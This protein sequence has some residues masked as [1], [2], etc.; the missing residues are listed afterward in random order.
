MNTSIFSGTRRTRR[1]AKLATAALLP[2]ALIGTLTSALTAA[3]AHADIDSTAAISAQT[4][5]MFTTASAW[6]PKAPSNAPGWKADFI[7]NFDGP[8]NT[9][10]WGRYQGGAPAGSH[11]AYTLANA[12]VTTSPTTTNSGILQLRTKYENGAWTSAGMSSGRGFAAVQGKWAI[13]ARFERG[14]GVGY[15][16]L[17]Y[18]KGGAWPPEVDLAEGTAGGASI[19]STVHYGT[20]KQNYQIQRWQHN[21]DMTKWHTYGVIISTGLIEYTL[22]GRVWGSVQ[23]DQTPDVP[24]WLGVQSG[25][26]DCAT[27][28]GECLSDQTP[29]N[30]AISIDWIAHYAKA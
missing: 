15:A 27:S 4:A 24:M 21:V 6:M 22:D 7:D 9:S 8:L 30:S 25:V 29:L 1:P 28:T 10:V 20:A 18:P 23:T 3:P 5:A 16:F 13:K 11:A 2:A 19:M 14:Y 17:L 12:T 26:K